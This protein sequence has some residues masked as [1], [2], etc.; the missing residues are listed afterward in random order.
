VYIA[1]ESW[2]VVDGFPGVSSYLV[3]DCFVDVCCDY[4]LDCD[5]FARICKFSHHFGFP[6]DGWMFIFVEYREF[7]TQV[8]TLIKIVFLFHFELFL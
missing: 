1:S 2:I 4:Y 5:M 6:F 7:L 3:D 8:L